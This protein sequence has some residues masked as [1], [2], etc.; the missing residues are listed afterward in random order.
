MKLFYKTFIL[1]V[2]FYPLY[3]HQT[4]AQNNVNDILY[5]SQLSEMLKAPVKMA[6]NTN[7][8]LYVTD[9]NQ[10]CILKY[11][12]L[13]QNPQKIFINGS[14][15][16][17]AINNAN[18]VF[19][20]KKTGE[21]VKLDAQGNES[22]FY[23]GC[24]LP[25][26]M[27]FSPESNL[28]IVDGKARNVSVIDEDGNLIRT[29]GEGIFLLPSSIAF[30]AGNQHILVSEHGGLKNVYK[31][32]KGL[33]D[34]VVKVWIFDLEGNVLGSFGQH[35]NTNG[36]FYR[37]QGLTI[38]KCG[39]IYVCDPF[40]GNISIFDKNGN[41]ITKFG[42][43]G[44]N[45]GQLN[46]P[47]DVLFDFQERIL[48]S[49]LNNGTIEVF[50]ISDSLP[51]SNIHNEYKE[52]CIG[53]STSFPVFF[54]GTSPW[55]FTYT[56]DNANPTTI[57]TS[58]NPYF[59]ST[60]QPG[61][62]TVTGLSDADYLGTCFTGFAQIIENPKPIS[63]ISCEDSVICENET[64]P[65]KIDFTGEAP[66][67]FN[68]SFAGGNPISITT[69]DNPHVMEVSDAGL[70]E[71]I[72]FEDA[73]CVGE[74]GS[75]PVNITVNPLPE[76]YITA[77]TPEFCFGDSTVLTFESTG[78]GPWTINYTLNGSRQTEII[79]SDNAFERY[80]D[81]KGIYGIL[82]T[83]D[84]L[85]SNTNLTSFIE[86]SD[87]PLPT[88]YI[89]LVDT[90]FCTGGTVQFPIQFTGTAPWSFSYLINNVS[91]TETVSGI[92]SNPYL[93]NAAI[94]GLYEL[95]SV[96]DVNCL[97][98]E[99]TGSAAI[100][101]YPAP[102]SDFDYVINGMQVNF[103]NHSMNSINFQWSFG[104]GTYSQEINPLHTYNAP[105]NY[106]VELIASNDLCGDNGMT[107]TF[108]IIAVSVN[109]IVSDDLI[110]IYPNPSLGI[111][112][113]EIK[114]IIS[115]DFKI[116]I[117]DMTGQTVLS[118]ECGF[119]NKTQEIDLRAFNNGVYS[120]RIRIEDHIYTSK[121]ILNK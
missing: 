65:I 19:I 32:D 95:S 74:I 36:K 28:Y 24:L 50:S 89:P 16:S 31:S 25:V 54:T 55:T 53:E 7:N 37:I 29:I 56:I 96:S 43:Y 1:F 8:E 78:N 71:L 111:V 61:I 72:S 52:I 5:T 57:T 85:C 87:L 20:G 9:Y 38:G 81:S 120:V 21:I 59:I 34:A 30:D 64:A 13:G 119:G 75:D 100:T 76:T 84:A 73:N 51:T 92:I 35:G 60:S 44:K 97:G 77:F 101:E 118:K 115:S 26:S 18:E 27:T 15:L 68:Y 4:R 11:D 82:T 2:L 104:D 58:E 63:V 105:G 83:T 66:W 109:E 67:T 86:I 99:M 46:V 23:S 114:G 41:F 93:I 110:K 10:N 3:I 113:I 88:A 91:P 94:P 98:N 40:L 12:E 17:I 22:L 108:S 47:T 121:L 42:E 102:I 39:N 69:F 62:Y 45:P 107:Q 103:L 116:E 90:F 14:P 106:A 112:K 49:S 6:V 48:V 33:F 117:Q 70:Y 80:T 79:T